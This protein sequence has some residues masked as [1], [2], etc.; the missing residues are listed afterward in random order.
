MDPRD[1]RAFVERP[2][3][4]PERLKRLY[5]ASS[6]SGEGAPSLGE[7]LY[8][9]ARQVDPSFPTAVYTREDFDHHL[10]LKALLDRAQAALE[11]R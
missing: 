11:A 5:W 10:R 1:I 7:L 2:R 6:A 9:H 8:E 4:E 3:D